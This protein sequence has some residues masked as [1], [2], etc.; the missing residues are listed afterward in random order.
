MPIASV[1]P[2]TG[3]TL[4]MFDEIRP[5]EV[6]AKLQLALTAFREH[7]RSSFADRAKNM[8]R[9]GEIL[10]SEADRLARLM[11]LEMGKTKQSAVAEAKKCAWVC[12]YYADHA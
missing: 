1:N 7:R 9:A 4:Q 11:V 8:R 6:E 3:Q 2:A 10:D 5:A 12:R